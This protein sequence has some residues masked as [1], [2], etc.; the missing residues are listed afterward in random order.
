MIINTSDGINPT[1][2][3]LGI[4]DFVV[5]EGA[6]GIWRYKKW[7]SGKAECWGASTGNRSMTTATG[8]LYY[9]SGSAD[10]PSGLFTGVETVE[11]TP[12]STYGVMASTS[13]ASASK[14]DFYLQCATARTASVVVSIHAIGR[15]K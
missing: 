9:A 14:V 2:E 6:S 1:P 11:L 8:S 10:F 4:K 5:E 15:W 13:A 12:H 7:N 3:E